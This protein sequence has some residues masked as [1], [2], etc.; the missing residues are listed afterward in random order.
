MCLKEVFDFYR[1]QQF[2]DVYTSVVYT[3]FTILITH[4]SYSFI[5]KASWPEAREKEGKHCCS[6]AW[7]AALGSLKDPSS[8]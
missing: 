4:F 6:V 5:S 1:E 7:I 8:E 2:K 3:A